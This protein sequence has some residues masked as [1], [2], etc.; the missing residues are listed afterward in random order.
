VGILLAGASVLVFGAH[1]WVAFWQAGV[2]HAGHLGNE[3]PVARLITAFGT[4]F[5]FNGHIQVAVVVHAM[6]ALVVLAAAG[7]TWRHAA[8]PSLRALGLAVATLEIT[9]YAFDYDLVF[10]VVPWLLMIRES[11]EDPGA[12]RPVFWLWVV[13]ALTTPVSYLLSIYTARSTASIPLIGLALA[14]AWASRTSRLSRSRAGAS[15]SR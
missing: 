1:A 7:Y 4:A 12:A 13:L 10:L 9:P 14:A 11:Y 15:S 2:Q 5:T 8:S 6:A 3:I